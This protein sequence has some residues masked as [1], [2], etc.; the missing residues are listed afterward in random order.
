[1]GI[2]PGSSFVLND[3]Q[4]PEGEADYHE[5]TIFSHP[6]SSPTIQHFVIFS[7][8]HSS[9]NTQTYR[10]KLWED[11]KVPYILEEGMSPS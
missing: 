2:D 11:A 9:L 4:L 7:Q 6:V 10:D 5:G 3:G 8:F 1:M